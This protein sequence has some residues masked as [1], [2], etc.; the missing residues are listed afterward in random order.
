V[1]TPGSGRAWLELARIS[2]LPTV[3]TNALVG[4][5]LAGGPG[6]PFA[7]REWGVLCAA[8]G[9]LY[10]AGMALNDVMDIEVD[11]GTRPDRPIPSGRIPRRTALLAVVAALATGLLLIA[12]VSTAAVGWGLALV[13]CIVAYDVLHKKVPATVVLMGGCRG[14]V[15]VVTAAAVGMPG[16]PRTLA[17]MAG[18]MTLYI[19]ALTVLARREDVDD[20]AARGLELVLPALVLA[21]A[22]LAATAMPLWAIGAGAL[23]LAW[24]GASFRHVWRTPSDPR[25]AVMAWL[26]GI[27]LADALFLALLD[28]PIQ[29]ATAVGCFLMTAWG[30]R[31]ILGT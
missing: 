27:C 16:D 23:V 30:H 21:P 5:C 15:Y 20:R 9:L 12:L 11:R 10:C 1:S 3:F 29:A 7:W 14:L 24:L 6:P 8:I 18:S 17:V 19:I 31:R 28:A 2:N 4:V 22:A 25:R 26:A 13:A